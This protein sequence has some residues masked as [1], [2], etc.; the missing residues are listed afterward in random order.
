MTILAETPNSFSHL[1]KV[2]CFISNWS[3]LTCPSLGGVQE[4]VCL[5]SSPGLQGY[6]D[7]FLQWDTEYT[8]FLVCLPLS[9]CFQYWNWSRQGQGMVTTKTRHNFCLKVQNLIILLNIKDLIFLFLNISQNWDYYYHKRPWKH[10]VTTK[11]A[12]ESRNGAGGKCGGS[13]GW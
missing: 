11:A 12:E 9:L 2:A 13:F 10:E 7:F 1:G 5:P 6:K 8:M 4:G 3:V